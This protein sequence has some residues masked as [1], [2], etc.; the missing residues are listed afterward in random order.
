M[1]A[2]IASMMILATATAGCGTIFNGGPAT[3]SPAPGVRVNG[4]PATQL[5]D[6][7]LPLTVE[8]DQGGGC[9]IQSSLS[10]PYLLLDIFLTFPIGIVVD[11]ITGD[12]KVLE[13]NCPGVIV[14]N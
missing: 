9:I 6:K 4:S 11:A 3:V 14:E 12:W 2:A 13:N 8:Y 5:A 7:Q 10:I 1:K